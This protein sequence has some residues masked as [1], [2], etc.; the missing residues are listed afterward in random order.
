L[1]RGRRLKGDF[2]RRPR[3][4]ETPDRA[5]VLGS[6]SPLDHVPPEYLYEIKGHTNASDKIESNAAKLQRA[7]KYTGQILRSVGVID[8]TGKP[9]DDL[10]QSQR[11]TAE[12][13]Q[14]LAILEN[15][16]MDATKEYIVSDTTIG[17]PHID[18]LDIR[19]TENLRIL[20][21]R[22]AVPLDG[23]AL[24]DPYQGQLEE[25]SSEKKRDAVAAFDVAANVIQS[26]ARNIGDLSISSTAPAA[27]A[28]VRIERLKHRLTGLRHRR[29]ALPTRF[30]KSSEYKVPERSMLRRLA[31]TVP[32]QR[33]T[34]SNRQLK[35]FTIN[36]ATRKRRML[37]R[38]ERVKAANLE[39]K[40]QQKREKE[41]EKRER[42]REAEIWESEE[43]EREVLEQ[44]EALLAR[45]GDRDGLK[46]LDDTSRGEALE[47]GRSR[48]KEPWR[49]AR[50]RT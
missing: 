36:K 28:A 11:I 48:C 38:V 20:L 30:S 26:R 4:P 19:P 1:L 50:P 49:G 12:A 8:R 42:Q 41:K 34:T 17:E 27:V 15:I 10:H 32:L 43:R 35:S 13:K 18:A 25:I 23:A 47:A 16:Q 29:L 14:K 39:L 33:W 31:Q 9:E 37:L 3:R 44:Q 21:R 6:K 7:E 45:I 40:E 24:L 2:N 5:G 46:E 22:E